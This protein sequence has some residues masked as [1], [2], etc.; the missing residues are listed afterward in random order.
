MSLLHPCAETSVDLLKNPDQRGMKKA[1]PTLLSWPRC[2]IGLCLTRLYVYFHCCVAR[3]A[4]CS[5]TTGSDRIFVFRRG[6][7]G[8]RPNRALK[9]KLLHPFP[10]FFSAARQWRGE[11]DIQHISYTLLSPDRRQPQ[12][13]TIRYSWTIRQQSPHLAATRSLPGTAACLASPSLL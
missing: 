8:Q 2:L 4:S 5:G 1:S 13:H 12:P 10:F 9:F 11:G 6:A 3:T 7:C